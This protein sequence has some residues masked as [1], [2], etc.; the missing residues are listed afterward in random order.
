MCARD[1]NALRL[2][3]TDVCTLFLSGVAKNLQ[4]QI[5]NEAFVKVLCC[6]AG[7]QQGHIENFNIRADFGGDVCPLLANFGIVTA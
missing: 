7:V 2:T 1:L 3:L 5:C 4:D 6:G